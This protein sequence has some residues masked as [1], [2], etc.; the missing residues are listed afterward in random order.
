MQPIEFCICAQED[1][2]KCFSFDTKKLT[3]ETK[4][5]ELKICDTF[6]VEKQQNV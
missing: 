5:C 2:N 4:V 1:E 3:A 6:L